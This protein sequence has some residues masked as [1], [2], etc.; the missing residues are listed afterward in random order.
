MQIDSC[1][2]A[3]VSADTGSAMK[4]MLDAWWARMTA[5]VLGG[6]MDAL[7]TLM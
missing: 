3:C 4:Q 5:N 1:S 7:H 2:T 6:K